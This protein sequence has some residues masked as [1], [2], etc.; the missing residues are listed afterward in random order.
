MTVL[1]FGPM[2]TSDD[3]AG[4]RK[5]PRSYR[6]QYDGFYYRGAWLPVGEVITPET[7][8]DDRMIEFGIQAGKI[9][10]LPLEPDAPPPEA[11]KPMITSDAP[12]RG[13][14]KRR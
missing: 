3:Q 11:A 13:P 2:P 8:A 7:E 1:L 5:A 10:G 12:T 4:G 14:T 9:H 6:V